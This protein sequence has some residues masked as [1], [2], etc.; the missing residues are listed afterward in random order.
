[1]VELEIQWFSY[2]S[3]FAKI[4]FL[5]S[6]EQLRKLW[7]AYLERIFIKDAFGMLKPNMQICQKSD[8]ELKIPEM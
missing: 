6:V 8:M 3:H 4:T 7:V 2:K 5:C 1:M